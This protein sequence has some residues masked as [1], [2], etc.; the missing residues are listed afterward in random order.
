MLKNSLL[1]LSSLFLIQRVLG[2][3][4]SHSLSS[5]SNQQ[6]NSVPSQPFTIS[7]E[8]PE[9]FERLLC[10]A[11]LVLLGGVFAGLTIGLMGLDQTNLYVLIESGTTKEKENAKVVLDLLDRGKHW[12]LVTLLLANVIVNETLPI[13]LDGVFNGGWQAVVMS[14]GLIVIFGEIIPQCESTI[15]VR[16]GLAIGAKTANV[17]L[18]LMYLMYPIAYPIALILDFFLGE[19][20]G[21]VYKKAGL[22]TLVSLH[23]AVH[24][25]DVDA[26]TSDEVTIIGAVLDLKSKPV[27]FI[28]TPMNDVFTL[29][30]DDIMDA[31]MVDK[32]LTA[33]Y[34]RIPI[35]TP[36]NKDSF[37]GMLLTKLLITYD[38]DDNMLVNQLPLST[39]PET[40]PDT[41]CLDI[42]NFFQEGKS[43]M[44]LVTNCPG[45]NRGALGVITL[46]D[47]IEELIGE[48]IIDETDVYIDVRNKV[49]VVR[50]QM[51]SKNFTHMA[52]HNRKRNADEQISFFVEKS[53]TYGAI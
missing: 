2:Q 1:R 24:P 46:E 21:T 17:V 29:S 14:T 41:S 30:T 28:M 35:H 47:V 42:L 5:L 16:H 52:A 9:F 36:D 50:R 51:A 23:Q 38:P 13:I 12:V 22:K 19:S 20:H 40:G 39:L 45:E 32:I 4:L 11:F 53:T 25:S 48:E 27:S 18:V 8:S 34:S 15:C 37:I 10:V 43:H 49:R 7:Y 44:A 31:E 6:Q 33:G 26:L 3:P